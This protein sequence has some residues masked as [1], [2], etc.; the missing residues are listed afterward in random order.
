ML[1]TTIRLL[2][3]RVSAR[4]FHASSYVLD[5]AFIYRSHGNPSEVL[6]ALTFP[7]LPPPPR[8]TLNVKFLLGSLNP[9]DINT[10]EGVYPSKPSL[11]SFSFEN[12]VYIA[13]NE[14]LAEVTSIGKGVR[15]FEVGDW[16]IMDKPQR[17]TW[18]T[19]KNMTP[20]E[21]VPLERVANLTEASAANM[22]VNFS[23]ARN[24]LDSSAP[25]RPTTRGSVV[26]QNGANSGVGQAVIQMAKADGVHTIN[27]VRMREDFEMLKK[28]LMDLGA[29][30]VFTYDDLADKQKRKEIMK[31]AADISRQL[32][33]EGSHLALNCVGGDAAT[34]MTQLLKSRDPL[35][36][37]YGAMSKKPFSFPAGA[38]I[39][40]NLRLEGFWQTRIANKQTQDE[41]RAVHGRILDYIRV[42]Q[43]KEPEHEVVVVQK[44]LSDEEAVRILRDVLD[45]L[46]KGK[47]GKK[48]MLRIE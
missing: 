46:G 20:D 43:L 36:V 9:A 44:K 28:H 48:V 10:I 7:P 1:S 2:P 40:S 19:S 29:S 23:S 34:Y 14:G 41:R 16:V 3:R 37:T 45:K 4:S 31:L 32:D 21:V 27:F 15:G 5:R 39:F 8:G 33:G 6:N 12:D 13:G 17:G 22:M 11:S 47:Y 30:Y 25:S 42:G 24:L 26:L 18:S 35:F 38:Q